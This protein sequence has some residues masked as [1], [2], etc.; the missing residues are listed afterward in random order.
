MRVIHLLL[1]VALVLPACGE[2]E[3]EFDR[4]IGRFCGRLEDSAFQEKHREV[5]Q[6]GGYLMNRHDEEYYE[7]I[8]ALD[9]LGRRPY[10]AAA[11]RCPE[12]FWLFAATQRGLDFDRHY[13]RRVELEY[14]ADRACERLREPAVAAWLAGQGDAAPDQELLEIFQAG[15]DLE[16]SDEQIGFVLS[17]HCSDLVERVK[18][19]VLVVGGGPEMS[20]AR[21]QAQETCAKL[22]H[23]LGQQESARAGALALAWA[24]EVADLGREGR[25]AHFGREGPHIRVTVAALRRALEERCP[26]AAAAVAGLPG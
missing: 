17:Y 2:P 26:E 22:E 20:Q 9:E 15:W 21:V 25:M 10:P 18:S 8:V 12:A 23:A 19:A 5:I 1:L 7:I 6:A 24:T 16:F 14:L 4:L 13:G 3:S 11:A